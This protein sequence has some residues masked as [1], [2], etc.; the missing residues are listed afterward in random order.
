M[1]GPLREADTAM[2][3][4]REIAAKLTRKIASGEFAVGTRLSTER[5]LA[6]Q[7][8]VTRPVVREALKRLEAIGLIQIRRG[9]GIYVRP[10][11]LMG[12]IEMFDVF[13]TAEDG[14][15]NLKF[16]SDAL[17]FREHMVRA[18]VRLAA[19]EHTDAQ[20]AEMTE[21]V[22]RRRALRDAGNLSEMEM[23]NNRI[24]QAVVAATHNQIYQLVY[25][26]MGSLFIRLRD[27]IDVP[28]A[29]LEQAQL[30]L[31]RLVEA[32]GYRD[33]EMAD[34][35]IGRYLAMVRRAVMQQQQ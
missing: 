5:D 27:H 20:L 4:S 25:N 19:T 10:I 12:G 32:F 14:T 21:L 35:L 33:A 34:L 23:L 8:G 16:L 17:I 28:F 15:I 3:R 7:F 31:E 29:G 6:Q 2:T 22:A 26:S 30:I 1:L 11:Q 13:L 24:F 18:I 9:S